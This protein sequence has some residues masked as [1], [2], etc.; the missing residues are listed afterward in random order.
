ME[1]EPPP[2]GCFT[3]LKAKA[4][5]VDDSGRLDITDAIALLNYLFLSGPEL[6]MPP[7]GSVWTA[8]RP[9]P[10]RDEAAALQEVA[11]LLS[12]WE[13]EH[14][15]VRLGLDASVTPH[16]VRVVTLSTGAPPQSGVLPEAAIIP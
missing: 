15:L 8:G 16:V 7:T 12:P 2:T 14:G 1:T 3:R 5:D 4:A 10:L 6:P 11:P 13:T 9:L